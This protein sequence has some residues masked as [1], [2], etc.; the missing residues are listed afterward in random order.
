MPEV[1][2]PPLPYVLPV[3]LPFLRYAKLLNGVVVEVMDSNADPASLDTSWK[4]SETAGPG[5]LSA[6][7]ITFTPPVVL[8]DPRKWW[9]D[10]GPFKD[11]LGADALA[12]A[13][14]TND[15]CKACIEMLNGRVYIDLA[16]PQVVTLLGLLQAT[17]QPT[18]N[19]IFAGSGP[20]TAPKILTITTTPT[21]EVERHIKG[22]V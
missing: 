19:A 6:D 12:I 21:T 7:G 17:S 1:I 10:V 20:M 22:L 14:S 4:A 8:P 3:I 11:R 9:I 16:G 13:A 2:F 15:A 5:W 18:A